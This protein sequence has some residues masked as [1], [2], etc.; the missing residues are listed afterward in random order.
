MAFLG[1]VI[2]LCVLALHFPN[3]GIA[4]VGRS[5][6]DQPEEQAIAI[7]ATGRWG[8]SSFIAL[9]QNHQEELCCGQ[10]VLQTHGG[11]FV[12]LKAT[13]WLNENPR[14]SVIILT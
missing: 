4:A 11:L 5:F 6:T 9:P 12:A 8:Y 10:F 14:I 1:L 2:L 7:T 13:F 3:V